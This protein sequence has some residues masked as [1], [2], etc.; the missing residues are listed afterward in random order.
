MPHNNTP[1]YTSMANQTLHRIVPEMDTKI[2][3]LYKVPLKQSNS[4]LTVQAGYMY[5]VYFNAVN[6]VLP[7]ELV[8]GAWEGGTVAIINQTQQQSDVG[9]DGPFVSF[10]WKF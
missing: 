2:A 6:E 1:A 9:L 7:T 4:E 10:A 5:S 3:M 8:P